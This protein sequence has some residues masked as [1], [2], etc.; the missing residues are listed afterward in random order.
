[1]GLMEII[2]STAERC[3]QKFP[4]NPIQSINYAITFG[5]LVKHDNCQKHYATGVLRAKN[6]RQKCVNRNKS[7]FITKESKYYQITP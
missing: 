3:L 2:I 4:S 6:S 1:M 7:K 5:A